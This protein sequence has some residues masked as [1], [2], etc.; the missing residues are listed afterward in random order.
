MEPRHEHADNAAGESLILALGDERRDRFL[1]A[2][3]AFV[4]GS[5]LERRSG[6]G[7]QH[8]AAQEQQNESSTG[9]HHADDPSK[10]SRHEHHD[11]GRE[12]EGGMHRDSA[13][14][15]RQIPAQRRMRA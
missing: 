10:P 9:H 11:R 15:A 4:A 6:R 1:R 12:Q 7:E 3:G 14:Q 5:H 13:D 8:A 2:S